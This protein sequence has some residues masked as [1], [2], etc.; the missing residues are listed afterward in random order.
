MLIRRLSERIIKEMQEINFTLWR[1]AESD[2]WSIEILG[3]LHSNVS[4]ETVDALV[5]YALVATQQTLIGPYSL[6]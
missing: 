4:M 3:K 6:N 1:N 5:E 2:D